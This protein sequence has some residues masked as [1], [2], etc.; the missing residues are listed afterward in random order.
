DQFNPVLIDAITVE[1]ETMAVPFDNH[2]WLLWYNRRL[3]EEAG[4]DPDNLP[5][6]GQEFIEWGQKLTTDVNGKHPNEEGFDPDNVEIWAMYP[7][8]TRYSF[9][10]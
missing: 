10:T 2:G 3:I 9:P 5:K 1:G 7:T 4:L 6:N 8:W